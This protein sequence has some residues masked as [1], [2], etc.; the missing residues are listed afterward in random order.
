MQHKAGMPLGPFMLSDLIGLDIVHDILKT[1]EEHIGPEY[2][3]HR[4]IKELFES[5]NWE[6]R[7]EKASTATRNDQA[8]TEDQAK[9]FD[10]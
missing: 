2:T 10:V 1:F 8:V 9:G 3:P 4:E 6:E 7:Q 5:R